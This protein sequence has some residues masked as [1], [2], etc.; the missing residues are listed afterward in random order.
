[1]NRNKKKTDNFSSDLLPML[2]IDIESLN[3]SAKNHFK[4]F[5]TIKC[6]SEHS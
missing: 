2:Y 3:E 5:I 6:R 4:S 1:M